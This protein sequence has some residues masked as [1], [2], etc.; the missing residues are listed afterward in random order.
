MYNKRLLNGFTNPSFHIVRNKNRT[1][2]RK[3]K[4]ERYVKVNE[5]LKIKQKY[6]NVKRSDIRVTY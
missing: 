6:F 2:R 4:D 1:R 5:I 3:C